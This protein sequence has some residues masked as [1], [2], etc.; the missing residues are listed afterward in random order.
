M[1]LP[2]YQFDLRPVMSARAD[3]NCSSVYEHACEAS[4][5]LKHAH[6]HTSDKE[7]CAS[8][9]TRTLLSQANI[10][11]NVLDKKTTY[12]FRCVCRHRAVHRRTLPL[13]C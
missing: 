2:E 4:R 8:A 10:F 3:I 7:E 5:P 13:Y 12:T 1:E 11:F 9:Y 6:A